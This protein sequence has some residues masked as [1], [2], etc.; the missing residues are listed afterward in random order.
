[1]NKIF[2]LK[3]KLN[4]VFKSISYQKN[5]PH[6]RHLFGEKSLVGD[7]TSNY[8][9]L[10]EYSQRITLGIA[11]EEAVKNSSGNILEIG[12]AEGWATCTFA[13]IAKKYGVKVYCIDPYSGAQEGTESVYAEFKQVCERYP[14]TIIHLRD[15]SLSDVAKQFIKD[16][17][18]SFAFVDGLHTK[19]AAYSDILLSLN[20][21]KSGD[22]LC[23][24]DTNNYTD[25]DAGAA[26]IQ[27]ANEG[28]IS[29]IN[30]DSDAEK[31][32][33]THKSWHFGEKI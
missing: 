30:I 32:I 24:D 2:M 20:S 14:D 9:R 8:G 6:V 11:A 17:H 31:I 7:S 27:A 3:E 33:F 1:M 10:I 18:I 26:M 25:R 15:S 16:T 21:M 28:K 22:I 19:D 12:C 23:V 5:Q 4:S 13:E 29:K